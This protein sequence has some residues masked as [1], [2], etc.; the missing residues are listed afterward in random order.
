MV[1]ALTAQRTP[2]HNAQV[3]IDNRNKS[4][5]RVVP[6]AGPQFLDDARDVTHQRTPGDIAMSGSI[7]DK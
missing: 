5:A 7:S 4:F 6:A 1:R 2:G 3:F